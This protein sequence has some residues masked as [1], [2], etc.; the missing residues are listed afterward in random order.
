[1]ARTLLSSLV[2]AVIASGAN[3]HAVWLQMEHGEL[4][5]VYGHG[6]ESDPYP[7]SKLTSVELC[8]TVGCTAIV[9]ADHGSHQT[10]ALP[11]DATGVVKTAFDNGFWSKD[12]KGEWHNKSKDE[13]PGA[14]EGGHYVKWSTHVTG[15]LA[16]PGKALGMPAE[17]VPLAD[18]MA[19]KAGDELPVQ[20]LLNGQPA[21]GA[22]VT[23]DYVNASGDAPLV[24]DA[25]GKLMIR[26]R[27]QGLNVIVAFISEPYP[28]PAKADEIG[29][30]A[31]LSFMLEHEEE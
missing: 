9:P 23:V 29:H 21:A 13:V 31:S 27:N 10:I 8:D 7:A 1:M 20:V 24:A 6:A 30:A 11:G 22:Q 19:L 15:H 14:V 2:L 18:P 17:I 3:A 4:A 12:D 25:D 26:V 28:D 16:D 5:V